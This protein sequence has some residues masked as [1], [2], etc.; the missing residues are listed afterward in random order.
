MDN[1]K[2]TVSDR[3]LWMKTMIG[4]QASWIVRKDPHTIVTEMEAAIRGGKRRRTGHRAGAE[5]CPIYDLSKRPGQAG[6]MTNTAADFQ[7]KNQRSTIQG[8]CSQFG[9]FTESG[10]SWKN[11]EFKIDL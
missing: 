4:G 11:L 1:L 7:Y 5:A 3:G 8:W 9:I 2:L 10:P 6:V